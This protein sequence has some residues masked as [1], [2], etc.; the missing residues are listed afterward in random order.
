MES[1]MAKSPETI[2]KKT[3]LGANNRPSIRETKIIERLEEFFGRP[4]R[5]LNDPL[6]QYFDGGAEAVRALFG[7]INR[8]DGF[9]DEMV[10]LTPGDLQGATTIGMIE[11]AI[12][13]WYLNNNWNIIRRPLGG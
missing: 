8:F 5:D 6:D 4:I 9:H 1:A 11:Y 7:P 12:V 10:R 13:R 2:E 3:N